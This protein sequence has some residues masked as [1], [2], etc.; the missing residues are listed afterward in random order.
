MQDL[1]LILLSGGYHECT[2]LWNEDPMGKGNYYKIYFVKEGNARIY[3]DGQ[4]HELSEGNAYFINGF[5]L[6]KQ[7]CDNL[8][9]VFWIHFIPESLFLTMFINDLN[10]FFMWNIESSIA[11]SINYEVI[12]TLFENANS[13]DPI[14]LE[15]LSLAHN[16]QVNSI[17]LMLLSDMMLYEK[18]K[19][20]EASYPLYVKLKPALDF[21][22]DNYKEDIKL[23][24]ISA[25]SFLNPIY[26]SR[27]FKKCFKT[28]PVHYLNMIRLNEAC[29]LLTRT[30]K[31]ILEI[32]EITGFCNQFYFSKVFKMH[33][34]KTPSEYRIT[35]IS[36]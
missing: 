28:A 15:T 31:S 17:I 2:T 36:P 13:K 32:S 18:T 10:P 14:L 16:F 23:E 8:M 21:M 34:R 33:F 19:S 30:D 1:N 9:N 20:L 24:E 6:D 3:L 26:F 5:L 22:N 29:R 27:L 7:R 4:W 35:K 11:K 25:K 12:P